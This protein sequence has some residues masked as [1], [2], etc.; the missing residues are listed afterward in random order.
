VVLLSGLAFA[1]LSRATTDRQL[2]HTSFHDTDADVLA[3]SVLDSIIGDFKQ[4]IFDG[5][6]K[7]S[8]NSGTATIYIPKDTGSGAAANT[9]PQRSGTSGLLPNLIRRSIVNDPM[10]A[11]GVPSRAS[12]V[13]SAP[14]DPAHPKR[15]DV[16]RARWNTHYLLPKLNTGD[17]GTEPVA[18]F[19][20]PDW[21]FVKAY[22]PSTQQAGPAVIISPNPLVIGRYAYAI[23]DEGGLLDVN[24][25]GFPT[26][27]TTAQSGRKGSVAFADLTALPYPIPNPNAGGVYQIDRLVGW[28]NYATTQPLNSFP[29][30][31]FAANFQ[32]DPTRATAFVTYVLNNTNG[33]LAVPTTTWIPPGGGQQ[34]T[35]QAFLQRQELIAFRRTSQFSANALQHLGTF[36]REQNIPTWL[37]P[38]HALNPVILHRFPLSRFEL[39][40]TTPP[41]IPAD[42]QAYFGL[43]Y[44][45]ASG[46]TA[47]HWRYVGTSGSTLLSDI[48]PVTAANQDPDLFPLLK[49][50][51]PAGTSI[52]E[53]LSIGASLI[54]QRDGNLDTTWIEFAGPL[55]T[56]KAFGIDVNPSTEPDAPPRP[57]TVRVLNRGFRNVGELGYAYRDA[58][59]P[60]DFQ[61]AASTDAPLLDLFTYNTA[62]P[63][64]GFLNLNTRNH[65]ALATV[66]KGAITTESPLAI[67]DSTG[68]ATTAA[69]SIATDAT[70]GTVAKPALS[71]A[72]LARLA[73]V[74]TN[75]PFSADD[76]TKKTIARALAEVGQ[77]RTWGLLIDVIAQSGHYAPGETDLTK[78]IVEGEQH[79]WVH[80]AIDRFTLQ[81]IDRQ[82]EGVVE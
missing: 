61:T 34:R 46:L 5:S 47:E 54:D 8:V 6:T 39:F 32:T 26:G 75:T 76:E 1:Y 41:S 10:P 52:S 37:P 19:T 11:P 80:V 43:V 48:P 81:V 3:R 28:R 64:A 36:S 62:T 63:R 4:E 72:D 53:I 9:V 23:Y 79:Y 77:V 20:A 65:Y 55:G 71:R 18:A 78:F 17:D 45:P 2:A 16:T 69:N 50:A 35:D 51:L 42:I 38:N 40:A 66:L 60:L 13:S 33:F 44:V 15:G 25:A 31:D 56:Q 58:S 67:V 59:T 49:Y 57:A 70:N 24:L 74:V 29:N 12:A 14:L 73:S 30:S 21:V 82:V 27:T 7:T 22:D 68:D